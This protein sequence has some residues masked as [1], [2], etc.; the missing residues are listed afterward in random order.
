MK[1][2]FPLRALTALLLAALVLLAGC[3]SEPAPAVSDPPAAAQESAPSYTPEPIVTPSPTEQPPLALGAPPISVP[4]DAVTVTNVDELLEALA[5]GRT[6]CL[7]PGTYDLSAAANYGEARANGSYAWETVYDGYGLV[8]SGLEGLSILAPEG[9]ELVTQP[10]YANVLRAENC[11]GLTL[12]GL[13]LGHTPEPGICTGGV[14]SL[15][16]SDGVTLE[17]CRLYGCG[18]LGVEAENCASLT[19]SCTEIYDCSY[20]AVRCTQCRDLLVSD[21]AVHDCGVG[22]DDWCWTLFELAY[23]RGAAL[24]NTRIFGNRC[25]QLL[26]SYRSAGTLMLGCEVER[27]EVREAVFDISGPSVLVEDCA[28]RRPIPSA[29]PFYIK[30]SGTVY[31]QDRE[32]TELLSFDLRRMEYARVEPS[33]LE[34]LRAETED[35]ATLGG[36]ERTV[37]AATADEL[38]AAIAPNTTILLDAGEYVLSD[39]ARYKLTDGAYYYWESCYDGATLVIDGVENLRIVGAGRGE[40]RL[41]TA[42]R[43]AA[44]IYLRNCENVSL[45]E[46]TAGHTPEQGFCSGNVLSLFGCGSVTV[47]GCGLFG[48]GVWGLDLMNCE[49]VEIRDTEIYECSAGAACIYDSAAVS[50]SGCSIHDCDEGLNGIQVSGSRVLFDLQSLSDGWYL[51]DHSVFLGRAD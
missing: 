29:Y 12:A 44:V 40:T 22:E 20:G 11:P 36:E 4:A 46:L 19:L 16:L 48:C 13:T 49:E 28:F 7:E 30:G 6:L 17:G 14:V 50:F 45:E 25:M 35:S 18:M 21:C 26:H 1:P 47:S 31:A 27:N 2:R 23:C 42:P 3:G 5:P 43:Y 39:A 41:V 9:A 37:H 10:R 51:F 24:L 34:E 38:L 8:L 32:G 15:S 33:E